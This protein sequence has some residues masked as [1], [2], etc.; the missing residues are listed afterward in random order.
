MRPALIIAVKD[1]RLRV[2]DRSAVILGLIAPLSLALV[3][4]FIFGDDV[5]AG[6]GDSFRPTYGLVDE[7]GG[8]VGE[9]FVDMLESLEAD[10]IVR[11]AAMTRD[12]AERL[13]EEFGDFATYFVLPSGLSRAVE[14]GRPATI[15]IV[16]PV[17]DPVATQIARSIAED[18]SS[19]VA[20][21]QL[22]LAAAVAIDPRGDAELMAA[23][24]KVTNPIGV[25]RIDATVRQLDGA[26]YLSA[27]MAVFFSFLTVSFGVASVFE[28]RDEGTLS[29]LLAAPMSSVSVLAA[30]AISSFALGVVSMAMLV[31]LSSILVGA[32]WGDPLGVGLL[33]VALVLAAM[34]TM[35]VV[36]AAAKTPEG[37]RNVQTMIALTLGVLGGAF[38]PISQAG[39]LVG[40]LTLLT[41]HAWFMRGLG[42]LAGG[43]G[44]ASV[45]PA[46]VGLVAFAVVVGI[47]ATYALRSRALS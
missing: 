21:T 35:A 18:F 7:D 38:F 44:A 28:E 40:R 11:V 12:E 8:V 36:G 42:D 14:Q 20:T 13:V 4:N 46:A 37:A 16:A 34:A 45:L 26:T 24:S 5:F 6:P 2:R 43:S 30:K 32:R 47:P 23:A 17:D 41:P 22:A 15:E 3:F 33:V 31:V 25:G 1:L 27:G 10:G 39:G 29:R 19:S 9:A